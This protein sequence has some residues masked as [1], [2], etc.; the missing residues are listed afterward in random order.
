MKMGYEMSL[1]QLQKLVI[2]PELRQAITV[3]QLPSLE[4]REYIAAEM[5]ENPVLELMD[6]PGGDGL[7]SLHEPILRETLGPSNGEAEVRAPAEGGDRAPDIDWQTY[8]EDA[9]DIGVIPRKGAPE[10]PDW[11]YESHVGAEVSFH[12]HLLFQLRMAPLTPRQ[13]RIGAVIVG[14]INDNGYLGM[15][16]E[17]IAVAAGARPDEVEEVLKVIQGFEPPGVGARTL[18]E[19][20]LIQLGTLG[21]EAG[22]LDLAREL[23]LHHLEELAD[24]G[25]GRLA[26]TLSRTVPEVRQA[27][28]IIRSLDPK[29]GREFSG[30][31]STVYVQPDVTVEKVDGEYVVMVT[32]VSAP[33]LTINSAYRE[34]LRHPGLDGGAAEF[35]K[36]RLNSAMWLIRAIEQR[37]NT[38]SRVAESVV[39]FQRDFL[40]KG[41]KYL[42]PLALRDVACDIGAHE[43]TVSRAAAG[44][45]MQTPRGVYEMKFFFANGIPTEYGRLAATEA[46]KRMIRDM[47]ETEDPRNPLTDHAIASDLRRQG[48]IIS[49]RTVAKYRDECLIPPSRLR[50]RF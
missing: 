12:E 43:S 42:R 34:M 9:S 31:R 32:D 40:D 1:R 30:S 49:R 14:A 38:L 35:I 6:D 26:E 21:P 15:T 33:R 22:D 29:P 47:I 50:Q 8:F 2:T 41:I 27:M 23:I 37:R 46:V 13:M 3:L 16:T 28:E 4:L 48:V 39:R 7:V 36:S 19:C 10:G 18:K 44:K 17:E 45:Y 25:F 20:L 11:L 5:R 24:G